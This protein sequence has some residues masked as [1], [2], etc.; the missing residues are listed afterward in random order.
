MFNNN[1]KLLKTK[2]QKLLLVASWQRPP[3][4]R[5]R[6]GGE[7]ERSAVL[8]VVQLLTDVSNLPPPAGACVA[9]VARTG[10]LFS[11][12]SDSLHLRPA[13]QSP[14]VCFCFLPAPPNPTRPALDIT[15][16]A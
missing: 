16:P 13:A 6:S 15:R 2:K 12:S 10:M 11:F 8:M 5:P 7:A 3:R 1:C 9:C 14:A 4:S